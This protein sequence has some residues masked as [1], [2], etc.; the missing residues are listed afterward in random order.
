[1]S[2][3]ASQSSRFVELIVCA[4]R[5]SRTAASIWLRISASSGEMSSVGPSPASRSNFVAMK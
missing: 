4:R 5:P 1:M 2:R 3:T